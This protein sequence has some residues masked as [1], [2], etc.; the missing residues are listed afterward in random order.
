ME[1][2]KTFVAGLVLMTLTLLFAYAATAQAQFYVPRRSVI[3]QFSN[4]VRVIRLGGR[5]FGINTQTRQF[6]SE[7]QLSASGAMPVG[8]Q[9]PTMPVGHQDPTMP[10]GHQDPTMPIGGAP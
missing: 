10:V 5:T 9:D 6:L 2:I 3:S 7:Q 8:H 4:G 1:S